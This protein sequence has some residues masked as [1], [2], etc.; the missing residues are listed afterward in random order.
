MNLC[1][2][3]WVQRDKRLGCALE[4]GT[5]VQAVERYSS[6]DALQGLF[7]NFL[8]DS[9]IRNLRSVTP[10]TLL[11]TGS[12]GGNLEL[13]GHLSLLQGFYQLQL[14]FS[15]LASKWLREIEL[16]MPCEKDTICKQKNNC[17][18]LKPTSQTQ[19]PITRN[20]YYHY[21]TF[22]ASTKKRLNL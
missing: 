18:S 20:T 22:C 11:L 5:R 10:L 13:R 1:T 14:T 6:T 21:N 19:R 7:P 17:F 3:K 8:H 2:V 9:K 4:T 15:L 16:S 12:S